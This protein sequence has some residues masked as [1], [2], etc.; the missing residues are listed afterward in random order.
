MERLS[1]HPGELSFVPGA[2]VARP[3]RHRA[4]L[5]AGRQ[6]HGHLDWIAAQ[7]HPNLG[8][9][10]VVRRPAGTNGD[11]AVRSFGDLKV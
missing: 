8:G 1:V 4:W 7:Q 10:Q 5:L 3:A 9:R 2:D 11:R 6:A